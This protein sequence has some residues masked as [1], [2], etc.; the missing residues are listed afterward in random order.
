MASWKSGSTRR[1]AAFRQW[2][3]C[4]RNAEA[5]EQRII[6]EELNVQENEEN[7]SWLTKEQIA[8]STVSRSI[9]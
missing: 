3:S 9:L 2:L 7:I 5:A 8:G 6:R 4:G 1:T